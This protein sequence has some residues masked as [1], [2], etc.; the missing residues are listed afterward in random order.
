[1]TNVRVF[2]GDGGQMEYKDVLADFARRTLQNLAYIRRLEEAQKDSGVSLECLSAF[3][4]TQQVNSLLGLIVF[5]KENYQKHI[6]KKTLAELVAEGWPSLRITRP[7]P[8]CTAE[9]KPTAQRT[10]C[11]DPSCACI[12]HQFTAREL[13]RCQANHRECETLA[14]LIRVLRNGVSH[15]NIEFRVD[16]ETREINFIEISNRCTCC[17]QITTTV[18]L[19]MEDVRQVAERYAQIII[20]HSQRSSADTNAQSCNATALQ[21][22]ANPPIVGW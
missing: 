11:D 13:A 2:G 7:Y 5:P 4:V 16:S 17:E 22:T 3:P 19:S 8:E 18:S 20:E 1:M 12:E 14:Q 6:P 9:G 21:Q 10:K 15:F